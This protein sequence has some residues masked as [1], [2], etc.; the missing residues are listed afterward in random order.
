MQDT[1]QGFN[2][3]DLVEWSIILDPDGVDRGD[4]DEIGKASLKSCDSMFSVVETLMSIARCAILTKISG[5]P[6][7]AIQALI[8]CYP[9]AVTQIRYIGTCINDSAAHFMPKNL[10]LFLERDQPATSVGIVV[11]SPLKYVIVGT[12]QPYSCDPD[13]HFV[14]A[15]HRACHVDR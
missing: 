11:R 13:Q 14:R 10:W 12:A 9:V 5:T 4:C 6:A 8:D 2:Q 15:G 3:S 7:F 1:A